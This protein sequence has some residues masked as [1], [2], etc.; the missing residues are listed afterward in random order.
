[1]DKTLIELV[2]QVELDLQRIPVDLFTKLIRVKVDYITRDP[3]EFGE[4]AHLNLGHTLGHALETLAQSY[5]KPIR[6]GEAVAA[7]ICFSLFLSQQ[8]NLI[9]DFLHKDSE[10]VFERRFCL[11]PVRDFIKDYL[12]ESNLGT[13]IDRL[14][15]LM[16]QDKK[17]SHIQGL[18][19][20]VLINSKAK[21]IE[22]R[23]FSRAALAEALGMWFGQRFFVKE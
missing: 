22:K 10:L 15:S 17:N 4:R 23:D 9:D 3:Y 7:G 12:A 6:H 16:E 20:F 2:G 21:I 8:A 14:L 1:M 11:S 18:V 19:S 5:G 13:L